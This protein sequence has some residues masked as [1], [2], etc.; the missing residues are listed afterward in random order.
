MH[1]CFQNRSFTTVAD[2][3]PS[4]QAK[5]SLKFHM[6]AAEMVAENKDFLTAAA[7]QQETGNGQRERETGQRE[8][9]NGTTGT[10]QRDNRTAS[11]ENDSTLKRRCLRPSRARAYFSPQRDLR[12]PEKTP[13][14][15]HILTLKS[16]PWCSSSNAIRQERLAKH[17]AIARHNTSTLLYFH[18]SASLL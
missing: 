17:N 14:F 8:R 5:R 13:C 10:G 11:T 2:L 9:D 15:V 12:L 3:W 6:E 1:R 18:L 7:L 16:H 4:F